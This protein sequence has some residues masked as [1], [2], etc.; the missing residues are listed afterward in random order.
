M[1]GL[2]S[3]P[4]NDIM[5][6]KQDQKFVKEPH[7]FL[8]HARWSRDLRMEQDC[9]MISAAFSSYI[10]LLAPECLLQQ[11]NALMGSTS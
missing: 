1:G 6:L 5:E 8:E 9:I 7:I 2:M 10:L 3:M 4:N 11:N